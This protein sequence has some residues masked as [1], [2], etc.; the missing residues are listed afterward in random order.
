MKSRKRKKVHKST[1][2]LP[3]K[4]GSVLFVIL[5]F[6]SFFFSRKPTIKEEHFVK[7][8]VS[9]LRLTPTPA[10]T[11][12]PTGLPTPTPF[13]L[14]GYCLKVP[15]LFYHHVQPES[16]AMALGQ[17]AL[18]VDSGQFD[19]QMGYLVNHGYSA[20][21]VKQI[22]D[23]L[24]NHTSLPPKSVAVTLDDGY[25]DAYTY[26]YPIFQKYHITAN[27]MI[28]T[29]LLGS[30]NYLSWGQLSEM[31]HSGLI[32]ISDHTWSHYAVTH[33]SVEKIK[34]EIETGKKQLEENL[35]VKV[36]TFTYPYGSYDNQAISVLKQNGFIA[37]FSVVPGFW[38]CD[39]FI[40][41]LHR[42]RIG[43][44]SLSSYGL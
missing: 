32:Y 16:Q 23:A 22:A 29:G 15:V 41:T 12:T 4:F 14:V 5:F 40:M 44:G 25:V 33:G 36:D 19:S 37:A 3:V 39:S 27:L 26:A 35:G 43:N 42:N 7:N 6:S 31:V 13:P 20:V 30:N 34:Y 18:T 24:L 10:S 11:P 8:P 17:K 28:P 21:T 1:L 38:Q 2:S 9:Y